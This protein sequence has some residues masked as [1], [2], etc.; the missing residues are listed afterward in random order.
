MFDEILTRCPIQTCKETKTRSFEIFFEDP[1]EPTNKIVEE[2]QNSI[3]KLNFK[4]TESATLLT[5]HP[6]NRAQSATRKE[7]EKKSLGIEEMEK[8]HVGRQETSR[9]LQSSS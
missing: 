7:E 2:L 5:S 3:L 4:F 9:Q 6:E 1:F 8:L